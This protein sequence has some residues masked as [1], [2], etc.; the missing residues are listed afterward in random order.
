MTFT[1]V[2][3]VL[4]LF[5]LWLFQDFIT[6]SEAGLVVNLHVF[7]ITDGI[8]FMFETILC[9]EKNFFKDQMFSIKK[10]IDVF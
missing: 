2:I 3:M 10:V 1:A 8:F 9:M 6:W 4:I 5:F 7:C